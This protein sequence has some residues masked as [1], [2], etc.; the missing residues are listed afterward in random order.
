LPYLFV[1]LFIIQSGDFDIVNL[2]NEDLLKL[3]SGSVRTF[4]INKRFNDLYVIVTYVTKRKFAV[5]VTSEHSAL[6]KVQCLEC[7]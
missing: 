6:R 4:K 1:E 7:W 5:R 3:A 2:L